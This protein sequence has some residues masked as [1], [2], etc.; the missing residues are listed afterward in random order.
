MLMPQRS[1]SNLDQLKFF[2]IASQQINNYTME[3]S[4][5]SAWGLQYAW[6]EEKKLSHGD[7]IKPVTPEHS[8]DF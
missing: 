4:C 8:L 2:L 6:C 7:N 5:V 1:K 3:G